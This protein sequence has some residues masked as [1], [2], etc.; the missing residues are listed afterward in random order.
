MGQA[1]ETSMSIWLFTNRVLRAFQRQHP[2]ADAK[3]KRLHSSDMMSLSLYLLT[4]FPFFDQQLERFSMA[5]RAG[6]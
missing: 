2:A 5:F 4:Y 6:E 1:M 3:S